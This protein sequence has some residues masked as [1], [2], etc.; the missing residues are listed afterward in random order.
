PKTSVTV[1]PAQTTSLPVGLKVFTIQIEAHGK[2]SPAEAVDLARAL[3]I[4]LWGAKNAKPE[5]LARAQTIAD[6]EKVPVKFFASD[7]EYGTWVN[8]PGLGTYSHTCDII[9]PA[10]SNFGA[11]LSNKGIVSWA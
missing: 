7:E 9:A 11:S 5:W 10:D 6:T 3:R 8:I 1:T 2:G 4:H